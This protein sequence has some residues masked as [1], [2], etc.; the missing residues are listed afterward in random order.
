MSIQFDNTAAGVVTLKPGA[1]GS[2]SMTLPIANAA[3]AFTNDGSGNMSFAATGTVTSVAQSFT[4]GIISVGGSPITSS[5]TLALTVAGTSGGIPYFSSASAWATSAALAANALVVGGGAG[6]APATVTTGTGVVTAL[7]VNTGTAG[8][9]VVNGGA[10]GTPS[11]GTLTSATGLPISTGVS[12]LGTGVATALG[13]NTGSAGAFVVN[14]GALGT[15]SSGTLTNATGLPIST[16]V[17]GLG[18]GVATALGIAIGSAGAPITFN[19]AL[20]TPSSGTV[21]NLTGTASININGTVGATTA[22]TGAFTT[23]SATGVITSTL[24]TGTAPFTVASTTQ[25]ANLNAATAGTATNLLGGTVT[26][27][28]SNSQSATAGAAGLIWNRTAADTTPFTQPRIIVYGVGSDGSNWG[29]FGY[30]SDASLRVIFAKTG[31]GAPLI[32]GTTSAADG[33]GTLTSVATLSTAGVFSTTSFS[34]AGTG[35]TGTAAS[36]N[37]GGNAAGLSATLAVGSGGT[38]VT[39]STGTGSVV[40]STSP[41]LVTPLLGTPTS[42]NLANCTFPTLNQNTSGTAAT[43]TQLSGTQQTNLITGKT[44]TVAD[45][46]LA[47]D[48]GSFSVRGDGTYPASISFHRPS[49]YAINMGLSTSN[50]F[51]IG[52]WSASSNAFKLTGAGAGTFLST[53]TAT[54]ITA[55]GNVTG[56]ATNVTGVVAVANGGTGLSSTPAN[57]ALNIG[58]GT[59]FTRATLTQGTGITITNGAGS[60]SIAASYAGIGDGQTW[61]TFTIGTNRIS[62]TTYTNSTGK[63]I[64]VLVTG[65]DASGQGLN[66]SITVGGVVIATGSNSTTYR[67]AWSFIVPIGATYVLSW[68]TS[69]DF[70]R[71]TELR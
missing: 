45:I 39:T 37:I 43:A 47:N 10:L 8:A 61:Q 40:L 64:M 35:L 18:T 15:P 13:V 30:G 49:I 9:F 6:A 70:N 38:G 62:G 36:L 51:V 25:V 33:T 54:N 20:G 66:L 55:A 42:G 16:G 1:S 56:T 22:S 2:Y 34:G 65:A 44:G 67:S 24:V 60:I 27:G 57:G 50:E 32:F 4:G 69:A 3:G 5:G 14:G 23:V 12:G 52:G 53:V 46:N 21:T 58:N 48:S 41:T 71:W 17:S 59:G 26:A 63:P 7:G 31:A 28:P 19:G 68:N 11:S 29:Y